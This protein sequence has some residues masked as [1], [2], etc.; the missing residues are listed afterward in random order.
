MRARE[1]FER[2]KVNLADGQGDLGHQGFLS[3]FD[4]FR[5]DP[6]KLMYGLTVHRGSLGRIDNT[7]GLTVTSVGFEVKHFPW[8]KQRFFYRGGITANALQPTASGGDSEGGHFWTY[9]LLTGVGVE[10]PLWRL[11][12]APEIGGRFARGSAGKRINMLYVALGVH[13]YVFKGDK[14]SRDQ[15]K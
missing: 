14:A 7:R 11:G 4:V 1:H 2:G 6:M 3:A 13:F 5:E 8:E 9:G 10:L 15:N 12:V